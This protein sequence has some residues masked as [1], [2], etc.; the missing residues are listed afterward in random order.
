[1]SKKTQ[2]RRRN[3]NMF[4]NKYDFSYLLK[5]CQNILM[6]YYHLNEFDLNSD[7]QSD[8]LAWN[9]FSSS[10]IA[11]ASCE[12][13]NSTLSSHQKQIERR[14]KMQYR[15]ARRMHNLTKVQLILNLNFLSILFWNIPHKHKNYFLHCDEKSCFVVIFHQ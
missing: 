13:T 1:M 15:R 3:E 6:Q 7:I 2:K 4:S 12:S 11:H 9:I 5:K 14:L 10:V 8:P